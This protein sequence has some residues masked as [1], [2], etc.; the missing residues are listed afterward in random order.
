MYQLKGEDSRPER[1]NAAVSMRAVLRQIR[2]RDPAYSPS[3]PRRPP[4]RYY[5]IHD[6]RRD[7]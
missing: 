7:L 2:S 3:D 4:A 5:G 6:S 1:R